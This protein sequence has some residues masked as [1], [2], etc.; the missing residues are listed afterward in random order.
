MVNLARM[1]AGLHELAGIVT[2]LPSRCVPPPAASVT[3]KLLIHSSDLGFS[4]LLVARSQ[5]LLVRYDPRLFPIQGRSM[6]Y[7][8]TI[9]V[10]RYVDIGRLDPSAC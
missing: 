3:S 9:M 6:G 2:E 7:V 5:S 8:I 10:N 1:L 4:L